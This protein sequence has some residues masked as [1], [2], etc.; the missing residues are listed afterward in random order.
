MFACVIYMLSALFTAFATSNSFSSLHS[1]QAALSPHRIHCINSVLFSAFKMDPPIEKLTS[2]NY[3]QW[4]EDMEMQL[5]SKQIFRLT[6]D[7]EAEPVLNHDKEKYFNK[8]DAT[9]GCVCLSISW[10]IIFHIKWLK[11]PKKVWSLF[12][13]Q[14]NLRVYQLDK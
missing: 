8:I 9:Y 3:H 7:T 1:P 4:K 14:D 2:F 5:R 6:M 11:T 10:D 13:K 12:D